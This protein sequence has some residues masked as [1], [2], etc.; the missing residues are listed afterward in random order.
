M[1]L[2]LRGQGLKKRDGSRGDLYVRIRIAL[3]D[4]LTPEETELF[5]QLARKSTFDPRKR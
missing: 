1:R 2:R 4:Q 3:P 5:R